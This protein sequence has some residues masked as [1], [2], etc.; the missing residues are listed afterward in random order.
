[1]INRASVVYASLLSLV[2]IVIG[3]NGFTYAD[4]TDMH[5]EPGG[6]SH[7]STAPFE[8]P[9]R[10]AALNMSSIQAYVREALTKSTQYI[11]WQFIDT[12]HLTPPPAVHVEYAAGRIILKK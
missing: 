9:V 6:H 3:A 7:G 8:D 4:H 1:M 2:V 12:T 11:P 5:N 10:L